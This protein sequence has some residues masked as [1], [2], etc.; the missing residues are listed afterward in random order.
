MNKGG[1]FYMEKIQILDVSFSYGEREI[2]KVDELTIYE[3][4]KIG[5]VG[6]NGTGKTTFLKLIHHDLEPETGVI[7]TKGKIAYAKQLDEKI[8]SAST[9]SGGEKMMEILEEKLQEKADILLL[10]EPSSNLDYVHLETLTRKLKKYKGTLLVISHDRALLDEVCNTILEIE[11]GKLQLYR[12]NYSSYQY[13]KQAQKQRKLDQ[14]E[15]GK[16]EKARLAQAI[17]KS[18]QRAKAMKKTP[19]RMGN[20]EARLH[21]RETENIREKV[22]KHKKAL[23][24]RV[25]QLEKLEKPKTDYQV[26]FRVLDSQKIKNKEVVSSDSFSLTIAGKRF[27][28]ESKFVIL[29]N[30]VTVLMGRNGSGKTTFIKEILKQNPKVHI[31]PQAKIGYFS[32]NL[33]ILNSTQTMLENIKE[34]SIQ[35]ESVIRSVLANL[36]LQ[37]NKIHQL[38]SSLSGGEKVKVALAKLLVAKANFLILDEPTKFLDIESINALT[39]LIKQYPGTILLVSH[40]RKLINEVADE[41]LIIEHQQLIHFSGNYTAYQKYQADRQKPNSNRNDNLLF[42]FQLSKLDTQIALTRDEQE[43]KNLMKQR[44]LLIKQYLEKKG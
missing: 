14:Y 13:Q 43:K 41:L 38:V 26:H 44:E 24:T 27:I 12:G 20:S 30:K 2:I 18:N 6:I 7:K 1:I 33:D 5:I 8:D 34:T 42:N 40:D 23:E 28:Q 35:E 9:K 36:N 29:T 39:E 16:K 19:T 25:N 4:Q 22:E 10:D 15:Q 11:E 32:Q 37:G 3:D 21:K 31:T 17:K